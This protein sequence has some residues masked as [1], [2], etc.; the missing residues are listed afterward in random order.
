MKGSVSTMYLIEFFTH[1]CINCIHSIEDVREVREVVDGSFPKNSLG[2]FA[3]LKVISIHSPKFTREKDVESIKAFCKRM[4]MEYSDV[5]NDPTCI[6]WNELG[7]TCWPTLLILGPNP[8][9]TGPNLLFSFMGE[10]HKEDLSIAIK[11]AMEYFQEKFILDNNVA[12]NNADT[13]VVDS[14]DGNVSARE[15]N[16]FLRFPGKLLCWS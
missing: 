15:S 2:G 12:N 5:V 6:L 3:G 9:G 8:E 14:V 10:D 11:T 13:S 16:S 7:V 1:C 4:K